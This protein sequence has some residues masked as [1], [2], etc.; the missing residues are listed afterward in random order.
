MDK[1]SRFMNLHMTNKQSE[2]GQKAFPLRGRCHTASPASRMTDEV[3]PPSACIPTLK[4]LI[5][6]TSSVTA[7]VKNAP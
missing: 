4:S 1:V 3:S 2:N 6:F 5:I 7:L